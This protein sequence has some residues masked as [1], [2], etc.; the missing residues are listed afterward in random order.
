MQ[1]MVIGIA[2]GTGS[3]KTTLTNRLKHHFGDD[4]SVIYHDNYYKQHDDLTYEERC[5]LNYDHPDAFD[6]DLFI[7]HLCALRA[8]QT[9]A[10]PVYDFTVHNRADKTLTV[11]PARVLI[12]EG[13]LIF[14]N[15]ELRELMDIKI[16]VD[17]D[18]DVRLL[19]RLS[20]DVRERGRSMDSVIGQYLATVK[21][22]HEQFVEPSKRY[23]DLIVLEGGENNVALDM[24]VRRV[25]RHL[26]GGDEA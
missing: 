6:T 7:E 8:G 12:V 16:F 9:I 25:E 21:P 18:A 3:G 5:Q 15:R 1:T 13:I 19:R 2:G 22:M 26:A 20:R 24:I 23:A 11:T 4:V 10:C 14:A 17:T